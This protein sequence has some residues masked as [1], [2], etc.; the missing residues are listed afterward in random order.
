M[1]GWFVKES[2]RQGDIMEKVYSKVW[3]HLMSSYKLVTDELVGINSHVQQVKRLL[4]SESG[5]VKIVGIHAMGGIGKTTIAKAV[6]NDLCSQFDRFC[7]VED[8]REILS[9][10]DGIVAL[11]S[12]IISGILRTDY[13]VKDVYAI[14]NRVCKHKVLVVLDDVNDLFQFDQILGKLDNYSLESRFIVT[15]RDKRV[16][17]VLQ[18][19]EFY[20]PGEMSK[21]HALQLFSKHAFG[22]N[23]PP[24]DDA[25]LFMEFVKVAAG[26][27]LALKIIG[28]LLFRR[29][30]EFWEAK[31]MEL[32]DIP[33]TKLQERLKVSYNELNDNEKQIFLDITCFFTG[34]NKEFPFY[35]WSDCKFFPESGINTLLLRSLVRLDERNQFW[36]HDHIR[37]LGRAIIRGE[38]SQHRWKRNRIWSYEDALDILKSEEGSDR[39]EILRVNMYVENL[40]LTDKE[41]KKLSGLR[42]LQVFGT[43]IG[44][45]K[46][47]LPNLRW[48]RLQNCRS[49]PSDLN[50]K[51]LV[52]L[53]MQNCPVKDDWKGWSGTKVA[54]NLKAIHLQYCDD[55][56]TAPDLSQCIS[57]ESID[58]RGCRRMSGEFHIGNL[59]KNLKLLSFSGTEI[60]KLTGDIGTLENLHVFDAGNLREFPSD[61]RKLS[62][63]EI[64]NLESQD[65]SSTGFLLPSSLNS[66]DISGLQRLPNFANL[67]NLTD[68]KLTKFQ[69]P[70]I[71]G[72]DT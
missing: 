28:L 70:E 3:S 37:D 64:L 53:E 58:L 6:Y 10:G 34:E 32:K 9:K 62:C 42:Y 19:C 43:L 49:I 41:F 18:E 5:G 60:T 4:C 68:L 48:L 54:S 21:D 45:F 39:I 52:I 69:V 31:L 66:L 50:M 44:Y 38:D 22:T 2:D 57:L 23:D 24:E 13:N 8:A 63:P 47:V 55:M 1:K 25:I 35:M 33:P 59:L 17:Q 67:N 65:G 71:Q 15:T 46:G 61:D 7:F 36:M 56:I 30:R 72:L 12:K 16:L 27:L 51:K 14:K 29:E 40:E 20:E 26:L 11:Q